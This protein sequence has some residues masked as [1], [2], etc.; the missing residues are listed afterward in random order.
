MSFL[1]LV[2]SYGYALTVDHVSLSNLGEVKPAD[3][4]EVTLNVSLFDAESGF[5]GMNYQLHY[6]TNLLTFAGVT[7]NSDKE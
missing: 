1:L 7:V 3:E 4:F 5:V 6:D 2:P